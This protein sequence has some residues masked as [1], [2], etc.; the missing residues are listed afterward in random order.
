[1]AMYVSGSGLRQIFAYLLG[2][3]DGTSW[4]RLAVAAPLIMGGSSLI[5]LRARRSTGS[6]SARRPR[7]TSASTSGASG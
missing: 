7:R 3:F 4:V 2:G 5:L 1:M 6:C